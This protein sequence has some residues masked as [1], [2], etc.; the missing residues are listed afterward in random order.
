VSYNSSVTTRQP[1][2]PL[3]DAVYDIRVTLSDH[4]GSLS[5]CVVAGPVA[6]KMLGIAVALFLPVVSSP[7]QGVRPLVWWLP[8]IL[9][10]VFLQSCLSRRGRAQDFSLGANKTETRE[11]GWSSWGGGAP[12]PPAK[13]IGER[14][15]PRPL[16]RFLLFSALRMV[17]PDTIILLM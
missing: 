12:S 11:Q 13:R 2:G 6:E 7:I 8:S 1:R 5:R 9:Y 16:K 10:P 4:T 14:C 3:A 15:E 17:S